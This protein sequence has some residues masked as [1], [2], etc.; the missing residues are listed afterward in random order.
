[1]ATN[2]E[3]ILRAV[4]Y[5]ESNLSEPLDLDRVAHAAGYSKYHLH[6]MFS[7]IV[8]M[9]VHTYTQRRRLTEAARALVFSKQSVLEIALASGYET[10]QSFSVAFRGLF[11]MSPQAFRRRLE[12][13]PFQLRFH[14]DQPAA[15]SPD[16]KYDIHTIEQEEITLLGY[17]ATTK[18]GFGII[19]RCWHSLHANLRHVTQRTSPDFLVGLNDYSSADCIDCDQPSFLYLAAAEVRADASVPRGMARKTLAPCRYVV[20]SFRENPKSS[21]QHVS[22]YIYREWFSQSTFQLNE[23]ARYDF[24]RYGESV[25]ASG[26]AE[27][28]YW[29]PVV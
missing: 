10:Q 24:V 11:R 23:H 20:F 25:D 18:Y 1:M 6:R 8:G 9:S 26:K 2:F 14:A 22:E 4:D 15:F 27:I 19:G 16:P 7:S 5:I 3:A 28:E 12:Y 21:M 17:E 13:L 29:V